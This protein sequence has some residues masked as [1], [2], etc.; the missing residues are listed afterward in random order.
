MLKQI[1]EFHEED[2]ER[3]FWAT[4]DS[5]DFVDWAKARQP[6]SPAGSR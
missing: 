4:R 2:A 6:L 5:T 3:E 1:P